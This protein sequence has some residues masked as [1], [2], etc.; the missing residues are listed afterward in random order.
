[1]CFFIPHQIKKVNLKLIQVIVAA[2]FIPGGKYL[3]GSLIKK[4]QKSGDQL[5][6]MAE[7]LI[8]DYSENI[9]TS[10]KIKDDVDSLFSSLYRQ[11]QGKC[12]LF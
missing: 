2:G 12:S 4:Y 7:R 10:T 1:M 9:K 11:T 3:L 8:D 6:S 5:I